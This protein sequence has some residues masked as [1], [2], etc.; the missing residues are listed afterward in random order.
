MDMFYRYDGD[1]IMLPK[2]CQLVY[3]LIVGYQAGF[4]SLYQRNNLNL[5]F[6]SRIGAPLLFFK[7]VC[8]NHYT[9]DTIYR[10]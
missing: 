8:V 5:I 7:I 4:R 2:N 3:A 1:A 10:L 6:E 9:N